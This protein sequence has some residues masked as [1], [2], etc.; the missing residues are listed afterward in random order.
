M[1][2]FDQQG[3]YDEVSAWVT[4]QSFLS[5][6]A[7]G[8]HYCLLEEKTVIQRSLDYI[9]GMLFSAWFKLS[10]QEQLRF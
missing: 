7:G 2:V 5:S 3:F 10:I 1:F 4:S 8:Q 6:N 9:G